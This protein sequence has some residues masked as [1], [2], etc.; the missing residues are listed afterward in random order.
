M[1][2]KG[3][4]TKAER[5]AL[6]KLLA[7]KDLRGRN[8]LRHVIWLNSTKPKYKKGDCFKVTD[9]SRRFF[10]V[11]AVNVNGRIKD[12]YNF[13]DE[14]VYRYELEVH[15]VNSDG[16]ETTSTICVPEFELR[17]K[18]KNNENTIDGSGKYADCMDVCIG[19]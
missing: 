7:E 8:Q 3:L 15:I 2:K 9:R 14:E 10:G 12:I 16:R 13:R 19:I 17:V 11:P 5:T 1:T 18:A 6:E 4:L